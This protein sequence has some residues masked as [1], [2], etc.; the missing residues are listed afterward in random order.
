MKADKTAGILPSQHTRHSRIS[1][2]RYY[3]LAAFLTHFLFI[4]LS[5]LP[6]WRE[7]PLLT[8]DAHTY[9]TPARNL[10]ENGAFSREQTSPYL[11]EPYRTVGYPIF[12]AGIVRLTG[13]YEYTLFLAA[14]TAG[15]AAWSA[16]RLS[17][18]WGFN[19]QARHVTG[20]I[21][22][23]LP[24]SLGLSSQLLTDAIA[25]HLTI[26]WIFLVYRGINHSSYHSLAASTICLWILQT[27]KPTYHIFGLVLAGA[28]IIFTHAKTLQ[29]HPPLVKVTL[30]RHSL[31]PML[32]LLIM[33]LLTTPIP[34][35][36]AYLNY[37]DHGVFAS[38]Y[39]GIETAREY[40]Q[41]RFIAEQ[42]GEEFGKVLFELRQSDRQAASKLTVPQSE[43]GRLYLVKKTEFSHFI[44]HHPLEAARLAIVEMLRQLAAPQ[45]FAIQIFWGDLPAWVRAAGSLLSLF[46]WACALYAGLQMGRTGNWQVPV[47][48]LGLLT[49]FLL[50]GSISHKVG[51]RLRFPADMTAIPLVAAG[52]SFLCK[53]IY[54]LIFSRSQS[55][56]G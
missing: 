49:F 35:L 42:R 22:A 54:T 20:I 53:N 5:L 7:I 10:L 8:G 1:L 44:F 15:L 17:E 26:F 13:K 6:G 40:F 38:N 27:L 24:N 18:E 33:L 36:N 51:A 31:N 47:Y 2:A 48:L 12:I 30:H 16:V 50:S 52:F 32:T 21:A 19:R 9:L 46:F 4:T 43:Y 45:E 29:L 39:L 37:R 23:L 55:L 41:G 28:W 3:A 56:R 34:L 11:W 25:G 14:L